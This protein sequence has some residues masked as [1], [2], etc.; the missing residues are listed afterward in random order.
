LTDQVDVR[1]AERGSPRGMRAPTAA[2][3]D[4]L[5]EVVAVRSFGSMRLR[6]GT[7]LLRLT[8]SA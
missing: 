5:D 8:R 3:L 1:G 4:L 7:S 6:L 2:V